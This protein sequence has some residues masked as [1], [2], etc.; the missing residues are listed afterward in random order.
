MCHF[1]YYV[2][3]KSIANCAK[4]L[5]SCQ[6]PCDP[7]DCST[8]GFS[9]HITTSQS[10]LKLVSI[11]CVIANQPS[12]PLSPLS[13]GFP[14]QEYWRGLP[15]HFLWTFLTQGLIWEALYGKVSQIYVCV[16]T[17]THTHTH[18]HN[19]P[20]SSD[21]KESTCNAGDLSWIPG[22]G[23]SPGKGIGYPLQYSWASSVT[24]RVKNMHAV[25][26]SWV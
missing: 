13:M 25:W 12:H 21:G 11:R 1:L 2:S 3:F 24:Q 23:R 18:T 9:V 5:H 4:L 16:H 20:G 26:E 15:L 22:L 17:H 19:F 14:R 10:L 7:M 8:P 6:T